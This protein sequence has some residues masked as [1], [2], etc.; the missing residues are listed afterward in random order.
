MKCVYSISMM[1][2]IYSIVFHMVIY[3]SFAIVRTIHQRGIFPSSITFLK[4][5]VMNSP[6][7][8]QINLFFFLF[9]AEEVLQGVAAG[10]DIF[11]ST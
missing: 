7:F 4:Y 11:D 3:C 9:L 6:F 1:Y 10:I 8:W 5:M 2:S